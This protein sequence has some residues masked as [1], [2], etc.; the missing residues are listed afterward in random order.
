MEELTIKDYIH[1][2]L[3]YEEQKIALLSRIDIGKHR[4]SQKTAKRRRLA[5]KRQIQ[6]NAPQQS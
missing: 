4:F 1:R 2:E 5:Q 3:S 6:G